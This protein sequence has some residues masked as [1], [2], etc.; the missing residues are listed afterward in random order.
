M[1]KAKQFELLD[2]DIDDEVNEQQVQDEHNHS[3]DGV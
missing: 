1:N 3:S 2:D